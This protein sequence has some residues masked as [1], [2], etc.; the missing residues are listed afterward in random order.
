MVIERIVDTST[1]DDDA[2]EQR[3]EV[4]L[5]P[6]GG[7]EKN[8]V[9]KPTKRYPII[10]VSS[11]IVYENP[12]IR[13]REDQTLRAGGATG[14]YGVVETKDSVAIGALNDD[15][16]LLLIYAYS[17]PTDTW[18]WFIPM[19]GGEGEEVLTAADRELRE[20]T[21]YAARYY[22]H[23]ASPI[24][25]FGILTER[26]AVVIARELH[27]VARPPAD[28]IDMIQKSKFISFEKISEMVRN[29][30]ICDNQTLA[31]IYLVE[32][33]LRPTS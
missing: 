18:S 33:H 25:W 7:R 17:Y 11:H 4:S 6:R 1:H 24:V 15:D 2:E 22:E 5:R 27:K 9:K 14:I 31:T 23:I 19:G 32:Q 26:T 21:G 16:E 3:I 13:V 20:E 10:T 12:W 30:E 29:G 28:D 8:N